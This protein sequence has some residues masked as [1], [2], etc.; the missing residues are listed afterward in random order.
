MAGK[1][2]EG[3]GKLAVIQV[4]GMVKVTQKVKDTI[5]MLN[6][7]RKNHCAVLDDTPANRGMLNKVKDF[8]AWGEI[9]EETFKKLVEA[10]GEEFQSREMDSRKKYS[11]RALE[12]N[13]K[14]YKKYFRLNSPRKGFEKKGI[15]IAFE[16]GG[17]LGYRGEKI[18]DLVLRML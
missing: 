15:K 18:N 13:G 3:K 10:R 9:S 8:V 14:K 4:R 7:T 16:A 12:F 1:K 5:L 6:L 17:A 2:N 11:Y